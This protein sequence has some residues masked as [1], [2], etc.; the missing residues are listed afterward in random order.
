MPSPVRL[1]SS[2]I[3]VPLIV[4]C[5]TAEPKGDPTGP[6]GPQPPNLPVAPSLYTPSFTSTIELNDPDHRFSL[7]FGTTDSL[8]AQVP[9]ANVRF[10]VT[11]GAMTP[12]FVSTDSL[13]RGQTSWMLPY[14]LLT[15]DTLFGCG[16][17]ATHDCNPMNPLF[18][19]GPAP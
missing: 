5:V 17:D 16:V 10:R 3:L 12:A 15:T 6:G 19:V 9:F 4:A 11:R 8:G 13:G 7:G 1:R 2:L 14:P 18:I